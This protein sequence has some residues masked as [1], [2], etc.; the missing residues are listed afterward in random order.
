MMAELAGALTA[1]FVQE[2]VIASRPDDPTAPFNR[3]SAAFLVPTITTTLGNSLAAG[4]GSPSNLV[5]KGVLMAGWTQFG[6]HIS[7]LIASGGINQQ[8]PLP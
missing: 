3:Q 7:E 2:R 5:F 8:V 1:G 6:W 4:L